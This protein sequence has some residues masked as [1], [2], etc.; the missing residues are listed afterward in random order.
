MRY[1]AACAAARAGCRHGKD[2]DQLDQERARWRRQ[3]LGWLRRDLTWLGRALDRGGA[4][5][6]ALVR[7]MMQHWMAD[8]D[9][10][11][12]CGRNALAGLPGEERQ[13][14]ER[15]WSD[16]GALLRRASATE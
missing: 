16:V 7:P 2:A 6:A 11:G 3:A 5:A 4:Q 12:V 1:A 8:G 10:A 9:L 15:L 13:D 14:W